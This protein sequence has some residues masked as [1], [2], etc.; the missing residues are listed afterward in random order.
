MVASDRPTPE[1]PRQRGGL[2]LPVLLIGAGLLVLAGQTGWLGWSS[3]AS[4]LNLW[5]LL[6]V[7]V[8]VDLLLGGRFRVWLALAFVALVAAVGITGFGVFPTASGTPLDV[9]R[10]IGTATEAR[11]SLS[12]GVSELRVRPGAEAGVLVSGTVVP[13]NGERIVEDFRV[14]G[15][16]ALYT[17]SSEQPR[18]GTSFTFGDRWTW[19]LALAES[20]PIDLRVETGVGRADF[21]L[22][23]VDLTR[24]A[25][26]TGVGALTVRLPAAGVYDASIETGVGASTIVVPAGIAAK[27]TTSRG[28]GAVT[29]RGDLQRSGDVYTSPGYGSANNRVNLRVSSGVGA[30]NIEVRD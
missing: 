19:D 6:L 7:V 2:L 27:I 4:I 9:M 3:I 24:L 10:P 30:V 29:V 11:I 21:D 16:T 15:S 26:N 18:F 12:T 14:A 23:G 20:L 1:R 28:V 22:R 8:G 13:R 17:L 5:P 25:M